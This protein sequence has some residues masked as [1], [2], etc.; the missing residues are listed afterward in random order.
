MQALQA[1]K[2]LVS[3]DMAKIM[4]MIIFGF[5]TMPL[6]PSACLSELYHVC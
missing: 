6:H 5:D 3:V 4:I 2:A 1:A